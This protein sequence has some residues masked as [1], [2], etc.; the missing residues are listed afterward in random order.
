MTRRAGVEGL[1]LGEVLQAHKHAFELVAAG[2]GEEGFL[3]G[4]V[5]AL[6]DLVAIH[7]HHAYFWSV[8]VFAFLMAS[9]FL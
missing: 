7:L 9:D 3:P 2:E 4:L 5:Y 6:G 1:R 8:G